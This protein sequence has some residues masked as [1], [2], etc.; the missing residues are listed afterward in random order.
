MQISL[1]TPMNTGAAGEKKIHT[2]LA[3]FISGITGVR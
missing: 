3:F 1:D 2:P